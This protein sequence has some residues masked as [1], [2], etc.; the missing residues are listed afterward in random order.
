MKS[1]R[2]KISR[3]GHYKIP[4][5]KAIR[6]ITRFL[7][8]LH[9]PKCYYVY[10]ELTPQFNDIGQHIGDSLVRK[11]AYGYGLKEAKDFVEAWFDYESPAKDEPMPTQPP[12]MPYPR[13]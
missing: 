4:D 3:S 6:T 1:L 11:E 12:W 7:G 2:K 13:N 10:E 8:K 9:V 5:I